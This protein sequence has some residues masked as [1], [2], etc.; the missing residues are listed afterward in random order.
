TFTAVVVLTLGLG[1]GAN[2]A[3][4]SLMDQVL[5]RLLPVKDA[6]QLVLLDTPG[7]YSGRT[8]SQYESFEPMSHAMYERLRAAN[9][10]FANMLAGCRIGAHVSGAGPTEE[11]RADLVSGTF[12]DTL[13]LQPALGRLITGDDDRPRAAASVVVLGHGYWKRRFAQDRGV[14][15]R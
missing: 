13:G 2:T 8:S 3:I 7:T 12:F 11:V 10:T 9:G 4:F 1:I 5:V 6:G 14:V 15:G